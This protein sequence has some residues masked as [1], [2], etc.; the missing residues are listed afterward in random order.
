MMAM[1]FTKARLLKIIPYLLL[2]VAVFA[3]Y[4]NIYD[5]AFLYDD[6]FL[7]QKNRFLSSFSYLTQIFS[8]S[9]TGGAGYKDSF[10]RPMQILAYL[11]IEQIFG[12]TNWAFHL[13]NLGL[14]TCNVLFV[15]KLSKKLSLKTLSAFFVAL[16]WALHP[17]HVEAITY[18]SATAD[19][20][21]TFFILASLLIM[22][23]Q[24]KP[25]QMFFGFLFFALGL[26]SK[27]SAIIFPGLLVSVIFLSSKGDSNIE[28]WRWK[29][30]VKTL[31]FWLTSC[32]YFALRQ[33]VLNFNQDFN[34]Y[35]QATVYT[36]H[37]FYRLLT[38]FATLPSYLELFFWPHDLHIDRD[39]E[40]YT[41]FS[42]LPLLGLFICL[43]GLF[44]LT[45][46]F[47][48]RRDGRFLFSAWV[49]LWFGA[50]YFP[51][52]GV[53]IPVNSL[54]L[55]HWM[56][57]PS[58]AIF[59]GLGH[60]IEPWLESP[61]RLLK[62]GT[63]AAL[64]TSAIALGVCTY[65]QNELWSDS[66]TLYSTILNYNPVHKPIRVLHN[67]AMAYSDRGDYLKALEEYKVLLNATPVY[68]ATYHN[69]ARIYASLKQYD[70]AE[71]YYLEALKASPDF[72]PS[73]EDLMSL[74]AYLGQTAKAQ[75]LKQKYQDSNRSSTGH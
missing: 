43:A 72:F 51:Q 12:K 50:A 32:F 45:Q 24:F 6:E 54:F 60:A 30:Y 19:T 23:P 27:E 49:T 34:M 40:I 16:L 74:Y 57:L 55:E 53:L 37:I 42:L 48:Y 11:F 47:R 21:Y 36:E 4:S 14:H 46:A 17:L 2:I 35:K 31:P 75:D 69:V 13:L 41:S 29:T 3:A 39:F 62:L 20:L 63:A 59:I 65:K 61:R 25:R 8:S 1:S 22:T 64:G 52:S 15:Y 66:I 56:Y 38:F 18:M 7:I 10:Y 26:M 70:L 58:I 71:K 28:R 5:F 44:S 67:L 73:Y 68:P 33:T 9:S